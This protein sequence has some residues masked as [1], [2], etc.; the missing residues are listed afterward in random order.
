[1]TNFV[2]SV[3]GKK[4]VLFKNMPVKKKNTICWR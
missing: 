2:Y 1:M 4:Q 3:T